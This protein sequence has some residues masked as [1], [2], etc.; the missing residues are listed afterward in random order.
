MKRN[1]TGILSNRRVEPGEAQRRIPRSQGRGKMWR[2]GVSVP[3]T[4]S[5]ASSLDRLLPKSGARLHSLLGSIR[6][7]SP[8]SRV[9]LECNLNSGGKTPPKAKY[10][11]ENRCNKYR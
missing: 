5:A 4:D 7:R 9:A 10:F 3:E 2:L 11:R 6:M 1:Q 8:W